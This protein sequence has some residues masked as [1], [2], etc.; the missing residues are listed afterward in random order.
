MSYSSWKSKEGA[1]MSYTEAAR[2]MR[3]GL[4]QEAHQRAVTYAAQ[5][6]EQQRQLDE[7]LGA[8]AVAEAAATREARCGCGRVEPSTSFLAFRET[9]ERHAEGRCVCGYNRLAH[10]PEVQRKNRDIGRR[11]LDHEFEQAPMRDFDT[12]YCGCR[13]WD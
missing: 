13:G 3:A 9:A 11:T 1:T 5:R 12:F 6:E 4:D 10:S 8:K 7:Y 2:A